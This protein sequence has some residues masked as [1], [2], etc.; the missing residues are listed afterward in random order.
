M[1]GF[2]VIGIGYWVGW[3]WAL[4]IWAWEMSYE[5]LVEAE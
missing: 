5:F 3:K 2:W 1:T 4:G